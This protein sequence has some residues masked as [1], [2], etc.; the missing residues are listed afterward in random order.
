MQVSN[1]W[2]RTI[3]VQEVRCNWSDGLKGGLERTMGLRLRGGVTR[4]T[5]DLS[6]GLSQCRGE[7]WERGVWRKYL[8]DLR[9]EEPQFHSTRETCRGVHL[10][11][12]KLYRGFRTSPSVQKV[13]TLLIS[14]KIDQETKRVDPPKS[15]LPLTTTWSILVLTPTSGFQRKDLLKDLNLLYL[16]NPSP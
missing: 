4:Y 6:S 2:K 15:R 8:P 1:C 16:I 3:V 14:S 5:F 7:V 11:H 12:R 9:W 10:L 13:N